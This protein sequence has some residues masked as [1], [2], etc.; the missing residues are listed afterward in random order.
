VFL[1]EDDLFVLADALIMKA[2]EFVAA[3][4]RWIPSE[5][6]YNEELSLKEIPTGSDNFDCVFWKDGCSVYD[7]RPIQC[8]NF[9]FWDFVLKDEGAW[10]RTAAGCPGMGKGELHPF[11]EIQARLNERREHPVIKRI[12]T[13]T[14]N[15]S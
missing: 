9:P 15:S 2:D 12:K 5:D 4:C 11:S 1:S 14:S 3:Y 10:N 8:R 13:W 7:S 6:G